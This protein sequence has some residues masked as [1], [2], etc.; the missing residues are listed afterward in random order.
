VAVI[1][2]DIRLAA[3]PS[4][5]GDTIRTWQQFWGSTDRVPILR[6]IAE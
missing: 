1:S 3:F 2:L 4:M 6:V 5:G